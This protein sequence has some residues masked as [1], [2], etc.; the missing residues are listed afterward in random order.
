MMNKITR[1][2]FLKTAGTAVLAVAAAGALSGCDGGGSSKPTPVTPTK[3]VTNQTGLDVT[4]MFIGFGKTTN[5]DNSISYMYN[6][7][8][9]VKNTTESAITLQKSIF[10]AKLDNG[11]E[12]QANSCMK[13]SDKENTWTESFVTEEL[14]AGETKFIVVDFMM[15]EAV[16]NSWMTTA[17]TVTL[18]VN[19]NDATAEFK[20]EHVAK[21]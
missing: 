15:S 11:V 20:V 9:N 10:S 19:N 7:Q 6:V 13:K 1:R 16:Y 4:D 3:P 8:M 2:T 12:Q 5:R 14:Q 18:I 21:N 17:H